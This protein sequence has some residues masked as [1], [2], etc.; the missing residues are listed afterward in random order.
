ELQLWDTSDTESTL[1]VTDADH[2]GTLMD[3]E[4]SC[5]EPQN[6]LHMLIPRLNSERRAI[7]E[8]LKDELPKLISVIDDDGSLQQALASSQSR[9]NFQTLPLIKRVEHSS[10]LLSPSY[11]DKRYYKETVK[12]ISNVLRHSCIT[13]A[14]KTTFTLFSQFRGLENTLPNM[15]RSKSVQETVRIL[16][17]LLSN[18]EIPDIETAKDLLRLG[19]ALW[20]L[21]LPDEASM[22][23]DWG[24]QICWKL[25]ELGNAGELVE[26][27]RFLHQLA[28]NLDGDE[29]LEE[30]ERVFE[31][32][33]KASSTSGESE[34]NSG[35]VV[36][37]EGGGGDPPRAWT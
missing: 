32:A 26:L 21:R 36:S 8:K 2:I 10:R 13:L 27:A 5:R 31:R 34:A 16:D 29:Q 28:M 1:S 12:D 18:K 24:V 3:K 6:A 30:A 22:M 33:V 37:T 15:S 14:Q 23:Y 35:L 7:L 4:K 25:A 20:C 9:D 17:L 19:G 11:I